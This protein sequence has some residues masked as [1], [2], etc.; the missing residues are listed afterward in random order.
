MN[1]AKFKATLVDFKVN[2]KKTVLKL[3]LTN[4]DASRNF[5]FLVGSLDED[6]LV[7]LGD[8]QVSMEELGV[9]TPHS[10]IPYNVQ[11]DG[12][13]DKAGEQQGDIFDGSQDMELEDGET[14]EAEADESEHEESNSEESDDL[15]LYYCDGEAPAD[16][17]SDEVE[18]SDETPEPKGEV[19]AWILNGN[20]FGDEEKDWETL[21]RRKKAGET[22][23]Q[24][25]S[26]IGTSSGKLSTAWSKYKKRVKQYLAGEEHGAA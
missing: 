2:G 9:R 19:E 4:N 3:E 15:E 25:A 23:M 13:V 11:Q 7:Q 22:W 21:L 10:G 6:V 5:G 16:S 24:I 26:S 18:E 1:S 14:Q 8:P 12:T 20:A 17:A